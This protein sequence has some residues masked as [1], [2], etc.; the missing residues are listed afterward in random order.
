MYRPSFT[1]QHS[2][3]LTKVNKHNLIDYYEEVFK[4]ERSLLKPNYIYNTELEEISYMEKTSGDQ[5]HIDNIEKTLLKE[6]VGFLIQECSSNQVILDIFNADKYE[7]RIGDRLVES[8][9]N[10]SVFIHENIF[11]TIDNKSNPSS[12]IILTPH[13]INEL[14]LVTI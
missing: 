5:A 14:E 12:S 1:V 13:Y 9:R 10:L 6:K 4:Y 11:I 2:R 7:I 8:R 3:L